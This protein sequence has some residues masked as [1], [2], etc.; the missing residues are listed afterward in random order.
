MSTL[1][2]VD[3]ESSIQADE[4]QS[5]RVPI[6]LLKDPYEAIRQA[7]LV[8]TDTESE[9]FEGKAR[10]PE[11]PY[12]VAPP[13][14]H[15]EESE[16]FGT[17]GAR[18]TSSD[19]T[20]SLSP[21]HPLTHTTP[22]FV[23]ILRRTARMVVG[24]FLALCWYSRVWKRYRGTFELILGTDSEEDE[25]VK[26]SSDSDSESEGIEDEGPTT[27]DEDPVAGDE[28]LAARVEVPG[29]DHKSYSLDDESYGLDDE[30]YG[31]DDES[32]GVDDESHGL[33][34]EGRGV[35]ID[36]LGLEKEEAVH[37]GQQQAALVVGT[38]VS[39]PLGLGYGALRCRELAL[40]GDHVYSTF[41][42]EQGFGSTSEPERSERVSASRQPTLT[43]WIDLED[44]MVYI[45]V[46]FLPTTSTAC[47]DTT[48]TR[49]DVWFTSHFTITLCRF[50]VRAAGDE[51]SCYCVRAG[52]GP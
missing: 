1:V 2:F 30:S 40:K 15:G 46:L 37:G 31:L 43:T 13:T 27:G 44:S 48:F 33:D 21:D 45:N 51:R 17:S 5:S 18:S 36:G 47:S 29:V 4:A 39:A 26:K 34:D 20:T 16:G 3:P 35:E 28:G 41:E 32:H 19:S 22:A 23:P 11:S 6:P 49:V 9:P 52:N 25:E 10:T 8:G 14:C 12:I 42:V 7:Y 24:F 50:T 38:I